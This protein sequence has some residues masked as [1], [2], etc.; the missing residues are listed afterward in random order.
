VPGVDALLIGPGDL[1]G[2]MGRPGEMG[3]PEVVAAIAAAVKRANAVGIPVGTVGPTVET[4]ALYREMGFDF[5]AIS[6]DLGLLMRSMSSALAG[7]RAAVSTPA[8]T[9]K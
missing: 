8:S 5:L 9:R 3:H 4:V 1:S 7:A 2:A 6:S